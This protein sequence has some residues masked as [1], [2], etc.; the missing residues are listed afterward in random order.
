MDLWDTA[1]PFLQNWLDE[2]MGM[3]ALV[4]NLKRNLPY[5]REHFADLPETLY[6][7]L[8]EQHQISKQLTE[9]NRKLNQRQHHHSKYIAFFMGSVMFW[10]TLWQFPVLPAWLSAVL[11]FSVFVIWVIGL[12]LK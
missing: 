1:K 8:Q 10:G 2:Q 9:I 5:M 3:K 12:I 11:F 6:E 4:R 7:A